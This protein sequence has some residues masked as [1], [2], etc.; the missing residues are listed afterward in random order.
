MTF[1]DEVLMAYARG[2]L[3]EPARSEVERAM[4]QDPVL[5]ARVARH[6]SLR[7]SAGE[8][9]GGVVDE[10]L[11]PRIAALHN[12]KVVHLDAIRAARQ[13]AHQ[14]APARPR[15]SWRQWTVL[16][17]ALAIGAVQGVVAYRLMQGE[18]G[19]AAV[20]GTEGALLAQGVLAQA[21]STQPGGS[22]GKVRIGTS[23]LSREGTWC[24]SFVLGSAGGLAC[25]AGE[26]WNIAV[27]AETQGN[28]IP[29][30]VRDV[31]AQ[32]L[33]GQ[34]LDEQGERTALRQGWRR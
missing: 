26:R 4:R 21:L 11:P 7:A 34:P 9:F 23:F 28:E 3:D 2:Q 32:R 22:G 27:L 14:P 33:A 6:R 1:P 16:A 20:D 29:R 19:L 8:V 25:R 18:P 5:A 17:A 30:P 15:W 24:R 12:S 10:Q 31:I 13:Q